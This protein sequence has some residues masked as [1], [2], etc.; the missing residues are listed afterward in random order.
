VGRSADPTEGGGAEPAASLGLTVG[1]D[2]PALLTDW[3]V[4]RGLPRATQRL[5]L[6]EPLDPPPAASLD[7]A[8]LVAAATPPILA[9]V[10]ALLARAS[11]ARVAVVSGI[12]RRGDVDALLEQIHAAGLELIAARPLRVA[13]VEGAELHASAE[14][15]APGGSSAAVALAEL[16]AATTGMGARG[17]RGPRVAVLGRAEPWVGDL[18]DPIPVDEAWAHDAFA[19]AREV[20]DAVL[21]GPGAPATPALRAAVERVRPQAPVLSVGAPGPDWAD[22]VDALV[23]RAPAPL[24]AGECGVVPRAS[25][26][27]D[28]T[29]EVHDADPDVAARALLERCARGE[30]LLAPS[31]PRAVADRVAA[32]LGD[33][34]TDAQGALAGIDAVE[35][36][37]R[38]LLVERHGV[39]LRR[40]AWRHH[41]VGHWWQ[42]R[43]AAQGRTG[44]WSPAASAIALVDDAT[45][46]QRIRAAMAAQTH[47]ALQLVL[48][49]RGVSAH[50]LEEPVGAL[51][52]R[53]VA[54][55]TQ[56]ADAEALM[57]GADAADGEI[58]VGL[59]GRDRYGPD[60]VHDLVEGLE[61]DGANLTGKGGEL[62]YDPLADRSQQRPDGELRQWGAA[63][64]AGSWAVRS[65]DLAAIGALPSDVEAHHELAR[66]VSR[67]GGAILRVHPF[68]HVVEASGT[69]AASA[70]WSTQG[71][72]LAL[73]E[74]DPAL[75]S[76]SDRQTPSSRGRS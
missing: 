75:P 68:G 23:P 38:A 74:A 73:L 45:A 48:V 36:G 53:V 41:E 39:A 6:R 65:G 43:L 2:A 56:T 9:R 71:L 28:P 64:V 25:T 24:V 33:L 51:D 19:L 34:V 27:V 1:S 54:V 12:G 52:E 8:L 49:L 3:L 63:L 35:P 4:D 44:R 40:A 11:K 26:L 57:R 72:P 47:R 32:P 13:G 46:A 58:V 31:L 20:P 70:R 10:Q 22:T 59:R 30:P 17:R 15:G 50:E 21:L 14:A 76:S 55:P 5:D 42:Q 67:W 61:V 62:S 66:R 69:A 16:A 18:D 7:L 29:A 60:H 37:L